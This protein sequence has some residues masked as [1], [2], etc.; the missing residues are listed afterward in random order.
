MESIV[1]GMINT[2]ILI[3]NVWLNI[4]IRLCRLIG[5]DSH[6]LIW[7]FFVGSIYPVIKIISCLLEGELFCFLW[8]AQKISM[9][10]LIL[11]WLR[12]I[13]CG[14]PVV[15]KER[16]TMGDGMTRQHCTVQA[17]NLHLLQWRPLRLEFVLSHSVCGQY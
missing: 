8:S 3:Y 15:F 6:I 13:D 10:Q 14:P 7:F 5:N 12:Y 11:A 16:P 9:V 1:L 17:E 2:F 4:W